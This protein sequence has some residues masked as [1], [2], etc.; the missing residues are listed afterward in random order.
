MKKLYVYHTIF[1]NYFMCL[2]VFAYKYVYALLCFWS[3]ERPEGDRSFRIE[4][5]MAVGHHV[6]VGN[7]TQVF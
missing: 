7:G 4:L 2:A 5:Q 3:P 6:G 1:N